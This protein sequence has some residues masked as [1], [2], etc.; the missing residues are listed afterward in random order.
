MHT[1]H[2]LAG[3]RFH[4]ARRGIVALVLLALVSTALGGTA[5]AQDAGETEDV[6]LKTYVNVQTNR[7][8]VVVI[9]DT[10]WVTVS[11]RG[12]ADVEDLRFVATLADGSVAYPANTVDH[13]GPYN[14]Y[15]LDKNE[16]DYVAFRVTIP[17]DLQ[18]KKVEMELEATFTH[19][20]QPMR[21]TDEVEIPL[22]QFDG[23]PYSLG[24]DQ[25]TLTDATNGWVEVSFAGLAPR[26][27]NFEVAI[28]DPTDL[29]VY[30]PL[31]TF[32]SLAGDALLE[33]GETDVVRFRLGE[34]HWGVDHAVQLTVRYQ[35]AGV[36]ESATHALSIVAA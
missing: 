18:E 28:S 4:R 36:A 15:E 27:E 21:G 24:S 7:T 11:L 32:T 34:A 6:R 16:T 35:L 29:D 31:E 5:Q 26:L 1:I 22:V 20:G 19:D 2:S 17:A 25:V 12:K 10:A 23:S 3:R 9:G 14:G 13:S 8:A 33:D 30:Y